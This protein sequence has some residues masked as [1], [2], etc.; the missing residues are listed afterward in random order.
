[1]SSKLSRHFVKAHK[2]GPRIKAIV[3]LR[4]GKRLAEF[5]KI[6]REGILVFN[7]EEA[8]KEYPEF[9]GQRKQRK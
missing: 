8:G 3:E 4:V 7:K 2:D 6:R 1:M 9:Q 5:A